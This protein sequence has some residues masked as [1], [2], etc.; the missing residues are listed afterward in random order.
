MRKVIVSAPVGER[1]GELRQFLTQEYRMSRTAANARIDR[2]YKFL[3][4]FGAPADHA[5]CRFRPW[6][7]LNYRCA[8]FE[9]WVFAYEIAPEGIIVRDMAHGKLLAEVDN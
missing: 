8:T 5:L 1:I 4:S 7:R 9:G 3:A 2:I 6:R